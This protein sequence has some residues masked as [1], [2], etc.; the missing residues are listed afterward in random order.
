LR[1]LH[2]K[3]LNGGRLPA[4]GRCGGLTH[5]GDLISKNETSGQNKI[6]TINSPGRGRGFGC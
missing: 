1:Q 3:L 6:H 2:G 5:G 4:F